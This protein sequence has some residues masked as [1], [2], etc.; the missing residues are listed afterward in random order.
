PVLLCGMLLAAAGAQEREAAAP[1]VAL[2]EIDGAIGPATAG[3]FEKAS[4]RAATNGASAIVL[5]IDTP[6]GLDGA[7]RDIVRTILNSPLPVI[8]YVAPDGARAAS[9][10]TYILYA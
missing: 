8:G 5:R 9:A 3:Y 10:G 6:G 1:H 7:T 4:R 2:I